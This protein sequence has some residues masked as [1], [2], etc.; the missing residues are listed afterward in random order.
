MDLKLDYKE[1][2][3]KVTKKVIDNFNEMSD[4]EFRAKYQVG[5]V[6]Y[7]KRVMKYGDPYMNAPLAKLG[8]LLG[9]LGFGK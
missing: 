4:S 7:Y 6:R 2:M 8:K 5:K 3:S 1:T 9:K